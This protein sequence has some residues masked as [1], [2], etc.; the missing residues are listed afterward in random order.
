M[1]KRD[2]AL[3]SSRLHARSQVTSSFANPAARKVISVVLVVV[4]VVVAVAVVCG[5]WLQPEHLVTRTIE[6]MAEDYYENYVQASFANSPEYSQ[7]DDL[8]VA[9]AKYE[10]YGFA[11]VTLRQLLSYDNAKNADKAALVLEYCDENA[12]SVKFYAEAPYGQRDYR[13]VYTY[14]CNF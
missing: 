1:A 13:A 5:I 8:S 6:S 9:M 12:T 3:R 2:N 4:V 10:S 14:S 11:P 7:L